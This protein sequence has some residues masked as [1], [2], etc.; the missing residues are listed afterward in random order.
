MSY[1]MFSNLRTED[2]KTNHF[3]IPASSQIFNYQ[4]ELVTILESDN[5]T[6]SNIDRYEHG[7]VHVVYFEFV[8]LMNLEEGD[9]YVKVRYNGKEYYIKKEKGQFSETELDLHQ[10]YFMS[11]AFRFRPVYTGE[12]SFCQH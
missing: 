10:N 9:F 12:Q 1:A 7:N 8:R 11:K 5:K 3:F 2:G 4:K 6:F